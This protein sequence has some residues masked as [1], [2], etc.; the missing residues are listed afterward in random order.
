MFGK[1]M[2]VRALCSL[3]PPALA[4]LPVV[5]VADP[6]QFYLTPFIGVESFDSDRN[7]YQ[8]GVYGV[9]G[10]YQFSDHFG[11]ELG[12][13]TT[14]DAET[15]PLKNDVNVNHLFLNGL[16]YFGRMGS[17]WD[18]YLKLGVGHVQYDYKRHFA[19]DDETQL[20]AGL[21]LRMHFTDRWSARAEAAALHETNSSYTN[22][23]YTLGVSYAFGGT[24]KQ[25]AP[26][27]M[28]AAPPEPLDSD[29]DGVPDNRDKCP[30]T[31][32][33]REVDANGCEY[34]LK[35]HKEIRLDVKFAFDKSDV[36]EEYMGEVEKVGKFLHRY[37]NVKAVIEGHTDSV[38]ATAYNQKLSQARADAV[39]DLLVQRFNIEASRLSAVGYGESKP[40]ASNETADGRAENRRVVAV[41]EAEVSVPQYKK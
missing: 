3:F 8:S 4:L 34:V 12:I 35:E 16:Y 38:G 22:A 28:P 27:P 9:S 29:G 1:S 23:L 18:P 7:I 6:G 15:H 30:N 24:P 36:T 26:A 37:G 39:K 21:G 32:R 19:D 31:P 33:G 17:L 10:E 11:A 2:K 41:M 40:I 14:A 25:A 13:S 5:A 20:A